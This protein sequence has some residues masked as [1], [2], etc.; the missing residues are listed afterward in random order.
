M[1]SFS[2]AIIVLLAA[3]AVWLR[4]DYCEKNGKDFLPL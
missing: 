2:G 3:F 1:L 4:C